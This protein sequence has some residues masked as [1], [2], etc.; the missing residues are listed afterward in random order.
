MDYN[1]GGDMFLSYTTRY[2]D[3]GNTIAQG[4]KNIV[5]YLGTS[6]SYML[7]PKTNSKVSLMLDYRSRNIQS[8][9]NDDVLIRI[10]VHSNLWNSYADY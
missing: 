8:N 1:F 4:R 2:Q 9:F 3:V 10:G 7:F 5:Q 6:L